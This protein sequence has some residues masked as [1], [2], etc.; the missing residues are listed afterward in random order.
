MSDEIDRPR[1][2]AVEP[3]II[4]PGRARSFEWPRDRIYA[5]HRIYV[6]PLGPVGIALIFLALGVLAAILLFAVIGAVLIW[7]PLLVGAV[8]AG[9]IV[10]MLRR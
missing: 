5:T 9:A 3:E 4:P 2:P 7:I 10:R 8:L 6:S 1:R